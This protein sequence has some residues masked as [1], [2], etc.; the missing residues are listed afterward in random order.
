MVEFFSEDLDGT[1]YLNVGFVFEVDGT[2]HRA[3]LGAFTGELEQESMTI[4][5][6]LVEQAAEFM[7]EIYEPLLMV[8]EPQEPLY[9]KKLHIVG[10]GSSNVEG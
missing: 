9:K 6:G 4:I 8:F 2:Q 7:V 1:E 3:V 5:K 10:G